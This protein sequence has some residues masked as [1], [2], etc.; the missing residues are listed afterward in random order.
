MK[1]N[2]IIL[3]VL[4]FV[5]TKTVCQNCTYTFSGIVED[6]HDKSPL[7]NATIHI[8]TLNKYALSDA[9]G[10]FEIPNLCK[11]KITV[12][13]AHLGCDTQLIEIDIASDIYKIIDLEHH[14]EELENVSI[15][16]I[17]GKQTKTAQE[18]VLKT[19]TI[20]KYSDKSLGDALKE[21][22]GVSS[23]NT[24]NNV[25]KP[26]ING[27]HSSRIIIMNNG[28][29]LQDQEWGIEHAPNVDINSA[30]Q[31]SVIKGAGALA[32][33]GDAIGGVVVLTPSKPILKDTLYGKT[34]LGGQTNGRGYAISS[35]LYKN[36]SSGWFANVQGSYKRNGDFKAPDYNLT[37]TGSAVKG[38]SARFGKKK[39]ESGF[40]AYYSYLNTEIGILRSAHIGNIFNLATAINADEPIIADDFSYDINNP[41]QEIE[42]HL[43]KANYFKRFKNFGK[44][45]VQ[46]DYQ[47]N[48]RFEFDIRIG[49]RNEIPA[50]DLRLKTHTL[51]ADVK[52]DNN[53]E[54]KYK[55]GILTRSQNN[56]ASPDTGVRRLIPDYDKYDFGVYTTTEWKIKD[57]LIAD[58]GLRYDFSSIDAEK[59]YRLSRWDERGYEGEFNDIITGSVLGSEV[60]LDVIDPNASQY[61]TNPVFD[62]NNISFAAGFRYQFNTHHW[63]T[64]NY[65]LASRAPNP[66]ELFSDGVHH[67]AARYE[68]GDLRIKS[69]RSNRLSASYGYESSK[70]NILAESFYNRIHDFIYLVPSATGILPT[71]RG[72]FPVWEYIQTDA[73]LF[74]IDLSADYQIASHWNA[75]HKSAFIKGYDTK[76]DLP[77]I[78]IPPF[79]TLNSITY[80]NTKWHNF[81]ASL[82]SEW[83]FEQKEFP[84]EFN[85]TVAIANQD[86]ILVD[87]SPPPAYH[88]MHLQSEIRLPAFKKSSLHIRFSVNNI[89]NTNY[90]NYLN[91]L[92]FFADDLGRNVKLQLQ[93][94]Y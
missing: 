51:S 43:F 44:V 15:K 4:F 90:R 6:F 9:E 32:Y 79:M 40:E 78:D 82:Q 80:T 20:E 8:K 86:D 65:N 71:I 38:L 48:D 69:E 27:L 13:I 77:L 16:A 67:S 59:F 76:S 73:L 50:I 52:V 22:P 10:K 28:V 5:L 91:R 70:L 83:T 85:Y 7:Q 3:M 12:E 1:S 45:A 75:S 41:K 34:I 25:V 2:R 17:A 72:P 81:N 60:I 57:D 31:I 35:S 61:L 66:S 56:F 53:L 46:Y 19:Q 49:D 94:N 93:L 24:G 39:F 26:I 92:R 29:R 55:F 87:L 11:G 64:L 88:L 14:I 84:S 42:H 47:H 33:G 23:L 30:G 18:T 36:Y 21:V 68:I 62:F 37:N 74:G 63:G 54:R 89:F 58:A